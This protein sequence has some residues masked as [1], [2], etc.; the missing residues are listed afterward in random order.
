V[1]ANS[2]VISNHHNW[3]MKDG[4]G[5]RRSAGAGDLLAAFNNFGWLRVNTDNTSKIATPFNN[6]GSVTVETAGGGLELQSKGEHTGSFDVI[7]G[8]SLDV[9]KSGMV[10]AAQAINAFRAASTVGGRGSVTVSAGGTLVADAGAEWTVGG[11][12]LDNTNPLLGE[13]A[14]VKLDRTATVGSFIWK[15]GLFKGTGQLKVAQNGVADLTDD[16]TREFE[17]VPLLVR[18]AMTWGAGDINMAEGANVIVD[19]FGV[20]NVNA[21]NKITAKH[22][23]NPLMVPFIAVRAGGVMQKG[24][25]AT[26]TIGPSVQNRGRDVRPDPRHPVPRR[27]GG[28]R[29]PPRRRLVGNA[30]G[31]QLRRLLRS[32]LGAQGRVRHGDVR[33][34]D[35]GRRARAGAGRGDGALA[36][37]MTWGRYG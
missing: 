16:E 18:G 3:Q 15:G 36:C 13:Q 25:A 10:G 19:Q 37:G 28:R 6:S 24:A 31:G 21:N 4:A 34:A 22:T 8:A 17:G 29:G 32:G 5:V 26:P 14:S 9:K 7:F 23:P 11:L 30:D 2:P 20:F 12:T 33:R 27:G 1:T 35:P